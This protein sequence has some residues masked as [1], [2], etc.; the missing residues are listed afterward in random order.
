MVDNVIADYR[1]IFKTCHRELRPAGLEGTFQKRAGKE[2]GAELCC[3][4]VHREMF[5]SQVQDED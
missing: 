2:R 3:Q 4:L 1:K 5:E